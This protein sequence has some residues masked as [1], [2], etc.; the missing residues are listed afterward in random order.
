MFVAPSVSWRT[1]QSQ[2]IAITKNKP[3]TPSFNTIFCL[4]T[5]IYADFF[6]K[7]KIACTIKH[8]VTRCIPA[9][10]SFC[11]NWERNKCLIMNSFPSSRS[12]PLT[13]RVFS[14]KGIMIEPKGRNKGR[15]GG[16]SAWEYQNTEPW[17][18]LLVNWRPIASCLLSLL[19]VRRRSNANANPVRQSLTDCAA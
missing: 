18:E 11:D 19:A 12:S 5:Y 4:F 7:T 3:K 1:S 15:R 9:I 8:L 10:P 6:F 14:R 2:S 17:L 13:F 16:E